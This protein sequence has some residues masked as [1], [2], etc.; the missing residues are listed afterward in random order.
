MKRGYIKG[1][2]WII[3]IW[4][5]LS[6][7]GLPLGW[8]EADEAVVSAERRAWPHTLRVVRVT[9][10]TFDLALM[11][12]TAAG[13]GQW[14]LSL[15]SRDGRTHFVSVGDRVGAW[16]VISFEP[17]DERVFVESV[18][19]WRV[20]KSGWATL[21]DGEGRRRQLEMGRL[22]PEDGRRATLASV[23]TGAIWDVRE[24][25]PVREAGS[26]VRVARIGEDSVAVEYRGRKMELDWAGEE[27]TV[28]LAE[29]RRQ[30]EEARRATMLAAAQ[31]RQEALERMRRQE[32]AEAAH[33][34]A[35]REPL[36]ERRPEWHF[37]TEYR[38]PSAYEVWL[39]R[40]GPDGAMRPFVVPRD[41]R[42]GYSSYGWRSFGYGQHAPVS[43]GSAPTTD[44]YESDASAPTREMVPPYASPMTPHPSARRR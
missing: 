23:A 19:A 29:L 9:D 30:R 11:S 28:R 20:R 8:A 31:Q 43:S 35:R 4:L 33:V 32:R 22:L 12:Y 3:S 36:P 40:Q 44:T 34:P 42:R 17:K 14:R 7:L 13:D 26:E 21:E 16:R 5:V 10:D 15:N 38:Y 41:F 2:K 27:D 1:M 39:M 37:G 18:G 25:E 24:G 6:S